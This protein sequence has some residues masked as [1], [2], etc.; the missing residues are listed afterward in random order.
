MAITV[1]SSPSTAGNNCSTN[2]PG[3]TATVP[4]TPEMGAPGAPAAQVVHAREDLVFVFFRQAERRVPEPA[5]LPQSGVNGRAVHCVPQMTQDRHDVRQ[6]RAAAEGVGKRL[7]PF[8]N[9][10]EPSLALPP[11]VMPAPSDR[12]QDVHE[13]G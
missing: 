9:L 3:S 13:P 7:A 8:S 1:L 11:G 4:P 6:G 10:C 2:W 12:E 5:V